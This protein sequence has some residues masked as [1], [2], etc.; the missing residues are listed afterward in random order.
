MFTFCKCCQVWFQMSFCSFCKLLL[1]SFL[2]TLR[3]VVPNH[4]LQI[5]QVV[6]LDHF[7]ANYYFSTMSLVN[8][9]NSHFYIIFFLTFWN[10][11]IHTIFHNFSM[12]RLVSIFRQGLKIVVPNQFLKILANCHSKILV[13]QR[14][15]KEGASQPVDV[16]EA[17]FRE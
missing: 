8:F 10:K 16:V 2:Q 6:I 14:T 11:K 5:L 15:L 7:F 1:R 13:W 9:S 12:C 4:L 17:E 3:K